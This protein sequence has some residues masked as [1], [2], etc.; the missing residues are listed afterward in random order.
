MQGVR[1]N[2]VKRL[3]NLNRWCVT[4]GFREDAPKIFFFVIEQLRWG[5]GVKG[6][7]QSS[8]IWAKLL[9]NGSLRSEERGVGKE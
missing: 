4:V 6:T 9:A 8:N 2:E 7:V 3:G 5:G 1:K